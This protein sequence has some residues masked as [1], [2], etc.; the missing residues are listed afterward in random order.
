MNPIDALIKYSNTRE[1]D[2]F[3]SSLEE[4]E[5]IKKNME[6]MHERTKELNALLQEQ[7]PDCFKDLVE[8]Y[9]VVS[10]RKRSNHIRTKKDIDYVIDKYKRT[11][12]KTNYASWYSPAPTK[13]VNWFPLA[14]FPPETLVYFG[15]ELETLGT[16]NICKLVQTAG[17]SIA[18][19]KHSASS[20]SKDNTKNTIDVGIRDAPWVE[21]LNRFPTSDSTSK[22]AEHV[23]KHK[24]GSN[25][26]SAVLEN[27]P[28]FFEVASEQD[29]RTLNIDPVRMLT[30]IDRCIETYD[31]VL[32]AFYEPFISKELMARRLVG[33]KKKSQATRAKLEKMLEVIQQSQS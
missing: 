6:N 17:C 3:A 5:Q 12:Y 29:I 30:M 28:D 1:K 25:R 33:G 13:P 22:Y 8:L 20:S 9:I 32:P 26:V 27:A 4:I 24:L 16:H 14:H 23:E 19:I 31:I 15:D 7:S 10:Q 18:L 2:L 21:L 11:N